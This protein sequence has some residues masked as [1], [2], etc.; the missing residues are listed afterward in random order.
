MLSITKTRSTGLAIISAAIITAALALVGAAPADARMVCTGIGT[1]KLQCRQAKGCA[2]K[3]SFTDG[4]S[5][6]LA[7]E[8]GDVEEVSGKKLKCNDGKWEAREGTS[9][10]GVPTTSGVLEVFSPLPTRPTPPPPV[11]THA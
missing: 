1:G 5:F 11:G 4:R 2:I 10:A 7:Y 8:D 3:V 9:R 6:D